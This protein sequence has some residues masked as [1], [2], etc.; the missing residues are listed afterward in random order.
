MLS[1]SSV[2]LIS[3]KVQRSSLISAL[4][5]LAQSRPSITSLY[6]LIK[7]FGPKLAILAWILFFHHEKTGLFLILTTM[8]QSKCM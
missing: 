2:Y 5:I 7:I 3:H 6:L 4:G 1:I 8:L